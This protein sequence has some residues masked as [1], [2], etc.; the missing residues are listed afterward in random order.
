[1]SREAAFLAQ[2]TGELPKMRSRN[3]EEQTEA[4]DELNLLL[5]DGYT[6]VS[7]SLISAGNRDLITL[8]LYKP[9]LEQPCAIV[10]S[11]EFDDPPLVDNSLPY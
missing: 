6:V 9:A 5:D 1:M 2:S 3:A 10:D 8:I 7:Q 4:L 11:F